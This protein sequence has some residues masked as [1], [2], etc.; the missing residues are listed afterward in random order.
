VGGFGVGRAEVAVGGET[1]SEQVVHQP[2]LD[3]LMLRNQLL[4]LLNRLVH[5]REDLGDAALPSERW[6]EDFMP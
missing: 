4:R 2:G 6:H 3:L 5:R 1:A